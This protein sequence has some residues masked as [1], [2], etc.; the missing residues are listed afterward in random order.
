MEGHSS[1]GTSILLNL[2][3]EE[4]V[5]QR[6]TECLREAGNIASTILGV[7]WWLR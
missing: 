3:G 7:A 6:R 2:G 4:S 5:Q 1:S